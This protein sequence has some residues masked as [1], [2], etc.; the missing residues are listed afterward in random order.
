V[1]SAVA[2]GTIWIPLIG[3]RG[4]FPVAPGVA[5]NVNPD[6]IFTPLNTT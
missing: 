4:T 1:K 6:V 2:A 5:V 3:E